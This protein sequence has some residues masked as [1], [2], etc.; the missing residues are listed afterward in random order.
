V[1]V[2]KVGQLFEVF[3][4]TLINSPPKFVTSFIRMTDSLM[5]IRMA[6]TLM[7]IRKADSLML[8]EDSF[9]KPT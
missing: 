1:R 9:E 6:D 3:Q 7:S 5:S 8:E 2:T 4:K